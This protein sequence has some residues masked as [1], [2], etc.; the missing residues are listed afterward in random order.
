MLSLVLGLVLPSEVYVVCAEPVPSVL[1]RSRAV[2]VRS[3]RRARPAHHAH[4]RSQGADPVAQAHAAVA[5]REARAS[6]VTPNCRLNHH[7]RLPNPPRD[8]RDVPTDPRTLSG[9]CCLRCDARVEDLPRSRQRRLLRVLHR[10]ELGPVGTQ[11]PPSGSPTQLRVKLE[12]LHDVLPKLRR[13]LGHVH[14]ERE[15]LVESRPLATHRR[16]PRTSQLGGKSRPEAVHAFEVGKARPDVAPAPD[17]EDVGPLCPPLR[18]THTEQTRF[19]AL[20]LLLHDVG[21]ETVGHRREHAGSPWGS[22]HRVP[23]ATPK[24]VSAVKCHPTLTPFPDT[25]ESILMS[26]LSRMENFFAYT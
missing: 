23:V 24:S 11:A 5:H 13:V 1:Q 2:H 14:P 7:D 21:P 17:G 25:D 16:R 12:P 18:F 10:L 8:P 4:I 3:L 9:E 20:F 15:L 19:H 26:S 22:C 6:L